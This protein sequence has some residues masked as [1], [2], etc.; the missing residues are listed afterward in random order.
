[1]T[2]NMG[3]PPRS[4]ASASSIPAAVDPGAQTMRGEVK[5]PTR[6]IAGGGGFNMLECIGRGSYGEVWRAEAPGG[7][8]VALKV[9]KWPVG[10]QLNQMELRS[11]ELLKRLRHPFLVQLQSYW[12]A[13]D[14]LFMAM[15]LADMSLEAM[16]EKYRREGHEGIPI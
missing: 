13:E 16:D 5:A 4:E 15:E 3:N 9:L 8:L 7:V 11:L 10:H 6:I 14:K 1:G 12:Q 2:M